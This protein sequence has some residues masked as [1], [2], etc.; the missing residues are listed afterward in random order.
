MTAATSA[1]LASSTERTSRND[2]ADDTTGAPAPGGVGSAAAPAV[3][4]A[5]RFSA[6]SAPTNSAMNSFFGAASSR[7][8]GSH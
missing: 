8:G 5:S 3:T 7:S 6:R 1:W 2:V 4:S